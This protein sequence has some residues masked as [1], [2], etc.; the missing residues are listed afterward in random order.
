MD[1]STNL[2]DFATTIQHLSNGIFEALWTTIFG[3][4]NGIFFI[5][6]YYYFKHKLDWIYAKWEEIYISITEKL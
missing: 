3:L 5:L 2:Y 1:H 4:A 6:V